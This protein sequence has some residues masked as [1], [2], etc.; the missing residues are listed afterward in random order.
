MGPSGGVPA[1]NGPPTQ[2]RIRRVAV[3]SWACPSDRP[4]GRRSTAHPRSAVPLAIRHCDESS[5][6][7]GVLGFRVRLI[8]DAISDGRGSAQSP[9][10][11]DIEATRDADDILVPLSEQVDSGISRWGGVDM[12][13]RANYEPI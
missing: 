9:R 1:S 7:A 10:E 8:V 13:G 3:K 2:L 12:A 5:R 6:G 11:A 4:H